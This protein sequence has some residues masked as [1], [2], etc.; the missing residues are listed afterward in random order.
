M[1]KAQD[2]R[3]SEKFKKHKKKDVYSKPKTIKNIKQNKIK[4]QNVNNINAV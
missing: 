2:I 4:Q 3:I 1:E